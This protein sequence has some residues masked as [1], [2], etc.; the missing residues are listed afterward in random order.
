MSTLNRVVAMA[1]VNTLD[2]HIL[3]VNDGAFNVIIAL[4]MRQIVLFI[5]IIERS[6]GTL[7]VF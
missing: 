2:N 5:I 3:R 6:A 7:L 1:V 4:K